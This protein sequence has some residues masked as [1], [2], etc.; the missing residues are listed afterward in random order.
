[1]LFVLSTYFILFI[2]SYIFKKALL[3]KDVSLYVT[4]LFVITSVLFIMSRVIL[5]LLI[6]YII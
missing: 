1:M 2:A 6:K 5:F 3:S 4:L